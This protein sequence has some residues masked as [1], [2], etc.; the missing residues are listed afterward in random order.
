MKVLSFVVS[1]WMVAAPVMMPARSMCSFKPVSLR[2]EHMLNPPVIEPSAPRL[3]WINEPV[4]PE[5]T[6][7]AQSA[8]RV[9][10]SSSRSLADSGCGDVWDS[11]RV[12]TGNSLNIRYSGGTLKPG[13]DYWW[14]V[15]VW[16]DKG[17]RSDWSDVATFVTGLNDDDW[18]AR[19]IGSP[20]QGEDASPEYRRAP[21]F[22][23]HFDADTVGLVSAKAF[24]SGLGYFEMKLNGVRVGDDRLVPN[25][26]NYGP[27]P[28]LLHARLPMEDRYSG[29]RVMYLAY[30]LLPSLKDGDNRIEATVGNGF[31]N[32]HASWVEGY[33]SPR[34]ICRIELT[35]ADGRTTKILT[36]ET[37]TAMPSHIVFNDIYGGE[38]YDATADG[39][40]APAVIRNAPEGKLT[41]HASPTDRVLRRLSPVD[42]RRQSDGSYLVDFG[43]EI[44]GWIALSDM[45]GN[46]GDT[47]SVTY[48]CESPLGVHK[49]VMDGSGSEN[50]SPSF[51]WYVFSRAVISG[52]ESL[53][54][55]QVTAEWIGTDVPVD[56]AFR[57]SD[58][59]VNRIVDI[60]Q[61]T[62]T[63]NMHGGVASDCPHRERNP[64]TGDGQVAS[65]MV[66][67]NY[68]AAAFYEKW[69]RD[70][71]DAQHPESGYVP[72]SA[73]W[74]PGCGG[75]VP[76]GAAMNI[77]PWE[78]YLNY[79]D[80][81]IITENY[82][83][84]KRQTDHMLGWL[85][86]EG[87]M[88]QRKPLPESEEPFYWFNLG[89]WSAPGELPSEE[90][91]HTFYLW[92]CADITSRAASAVV[93]DEDCMRYGEIA[94][95]VHNAF[96]NKFYNPAER[97]Y[98]RFGSNVFALMMGV[99]DEFRAGVVESLRREIED[100]EGSH[101]NTGIF[102]TRYLFTV[103][104]ENGLADLAY[105]V[106]TQP[107]FPG[108]VNWIDQGATT[109]WEQWDGGNSRNHPMF[110]GGLVWLYR[111]L[112]GV[113]YDPENP[114]YRHVV[115]R[116]VP[117]ASLGDVRYVKN[118]PL[119]RL[120]SYVKYTPDGKG[121]LELVVP[122][123]S[124][125]TVFLPGSDLPIEVGQGIHS[126][127][128]FVGDMEGIE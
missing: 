82:D 124:T 56:A 73:P 122:V 15:Q 115:V 29:S 71:R 18:E 119:G 27:R 33:G 107:G 19:W 125:A 2:V 72:N 95:N 121:T 97:S 4:S 52:L 120:S 45:E 41:A 65:A 81:T 62:Q 80:S 12:E 43:E 117:V 118:T 9:I 74:E 102:G 128:F 8:Y 112:A 28:G 22:V 104:A 86:P 77:I 10:V 35:Y 1:L 123:G 51:T 54:P 116:P 55:K 126:F 14:R 64:Y 17:E 37:W 94:R 109:M 79:G 6:G 78:H 32:S 50:Y 7:A 83:A 36:D 63:D 84:M 91:V 96:H 20:G 106:L 26:T 61:R 68:D 98:G 58:P 44:S 110:G 59:M 75:G 53:E 66:M 3:E 5:I 88:L 111:N 85:T 93:N 39:E 100:E 114:G 47:V 13:T 92:M 30:D 24:V 57:C 23:K 34:F 108:Y 105:K 101:L 113:N 11:G 49:Y 16:D 42:L 46:R 76:W 127:D 70:M 89:E 90:L 31:Y 60:W 40:A 103:L 99:P 87:T 25:L 67:A 48:Q 21:M 38:I 69:I